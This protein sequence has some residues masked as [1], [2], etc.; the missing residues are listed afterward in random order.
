MQAGAILDGIYLP[1]L[2][3]EAERPQYWSKSPNLGNLS[4]S[5]MSNSNYDITFRQKTQGRIK[6]KID[7]IASSLI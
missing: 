4:Y 1:I 3:I 7:P 2:T 5:T 6:R